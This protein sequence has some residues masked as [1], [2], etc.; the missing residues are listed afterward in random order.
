MR[1]EILA[2][3]AA[4]AVLT[5]SLPTSTN[6]VVHEKRGGSSNWSQKEGVKPDSRI[7]LPIRIGLAE[8]NLHRGDEILMEVSDPASDRYGKHLT[9][10][11]VRKFGS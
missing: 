3:T 7:K 11:R 4:F 1:F 8:Q 2:A 5:A 9:P 10:E 6:Y